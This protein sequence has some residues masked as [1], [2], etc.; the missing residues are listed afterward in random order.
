[1]EEKPSLP[2]G[3]ESMLKGGK[4]LE[5]LPGKKVQREGGETNANLF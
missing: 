2:S 3:S 4:G 5:E 1:M